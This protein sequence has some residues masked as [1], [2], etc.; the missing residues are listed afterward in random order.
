MVVMKYRDSIHNREY[1]CFCYHDSIVLLYHGLSSVRALCV[2]LSMHMH[3][4]AWYLYV[5]IYNTYV[6]TVC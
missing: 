1:C 3:T 4:S 6:C 2:C 5:G